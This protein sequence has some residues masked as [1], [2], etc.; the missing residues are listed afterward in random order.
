M[1][2]LVEQ[3]ECAGCGVGALALRDQGLLQRS[4]V[5]AL[6]LALGTRVRLRGQLNVAHKLST[7]PLV[8]FF[9]RLSGLLTLVE[10]VAK[11]CRR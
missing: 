6:D 9:E 11:L 5:A 2:L 10:A 7:E 8:V 1:Q 4:H 3:P